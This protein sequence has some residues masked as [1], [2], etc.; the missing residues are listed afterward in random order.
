MKYP[1]PC[2]LV[3]HVAQPTFLGG[4]QNY[5]RPD[6]WPTHD[7]NDSLPLDELSAFG[8]LNAGSRG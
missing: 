7:G 8:S 5:C 1:Q 6:D 2:I 3:H 4:S